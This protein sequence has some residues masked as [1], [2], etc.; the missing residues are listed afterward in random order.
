MSVRVRSSPATVR[1]LISVNQPR[2]L[3]CIEAECWQ[4]DLYCL[5]YTHDHDCMYINGTGT[6]TYE[7]YIQL[8]RCGTLGGSDHHK[9]EVKNRNPTVWDLSLVEPMSCW[10]PSP[11]TE[12]RV[13]SQVW[14]IWFKLKLNV[15]LLAIKSWWK[16]IGLRRFTITVITTIMT[17]L[18]LDNY[19]S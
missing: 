4:S 19:V 9:R 15:K 2:S 1:E 12:S 5:G 14:Y 13:M 10:R 11:V 3:Y 8:N 6:N 16:L 18:L 17:S 7:F